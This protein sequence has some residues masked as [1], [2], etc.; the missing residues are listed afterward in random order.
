MVM[1]AGAAVA[2]RG[3]DP[4]RARAALT[5]VRETAAAS[6]AELDRLMAVIHEGA[7]GLPLPADA[8]PGALP[9]LVQRMRTAGL[10][11][12]FDQ[13]GRVDAALDRVV[14]RV[15]QEALT[16][17]LRHA[18]GAAVHVTVTAGA[19]EV[20]IRVQDDG[21]GPAQNTRRGFGLVGITERI[22]S[23][24]G[25]L[26][27]GPARGGGFQVHARIPAAVEVQA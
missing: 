24:G 11:V 13:T 21:P 22:G 1:Q 27:T 17:A 16:N 26:V 19:D 23:L 12:R 6:L 25:D 2:L 10:T 5:V 20:E 18:P 8:A 15:V 7:M 14:Y 9:D 3:A 4:G